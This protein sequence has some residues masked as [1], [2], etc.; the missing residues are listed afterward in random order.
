MT[1]IN[2][3]PIGSDGA[4]AIMRAMRKND[5]EP[6][7]IGI[8][9]CTLNNVVV[10]DPSNP[11]GTYSLDLSQAYDRVRTQAVADGIGC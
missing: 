3:N 7:S 5:V 8:Q 4:R 10:F 6:R 9:S 2:S 11:A 1:Q